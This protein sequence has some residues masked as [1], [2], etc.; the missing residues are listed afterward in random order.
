ESLHNHEGVTSILFGAGDAGF[1]DSTSSGTPVIVRLEARDLNND[2]HEDIVL[3]TDM[4]FQGSSI[5]EIQ[6]RLGDGTGDVPVSVHWSSSTP[7]LENPF[8]VKVGD[9]DEDGLDDLIVSNRSLVNPGVFFFR[10][11]GGGAFHDPVPLPDSFFNDTAIRYVEVADFNTDGHLDVDAGVVGMY[12]GDGAGGFTRI[13]PQP[14]AWSWSIG[15]FNGDSTLDIIE[16]GLSSNLSIAFGNGDGTFTPSSS[17]QLS[18][19]PRGQPIARDLDSNGTIDAIISDGHGAHFLLNDGTGVLTEAGQINLF[20]IPVS[21]ISA[22]DF[23]HDGFMDVILHTE[24]FDTPAASDIYRQIPPPPAC[25]ADLNGD[26][27]LDLLDVG[28]F[29]TAF[30]SMNPDA[31]LNGDGVLDLNDVAL[32]LDLFTNGCP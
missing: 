11:S 14:T 29:V 9:F 7:M 32:F 5:G 2:G 19:A 22:L 13:Q 26:G 6:V 18:F 1:L 3:T 4:V 16:I 30:T 15:D 21:H 31:D 24:L 28:A 8:D 17:M 27:I 10:A 23:D 25:P 20:T 12:L